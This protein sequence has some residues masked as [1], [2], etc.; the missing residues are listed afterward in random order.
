M[1]GSNKN[2][3]LRNLSQETKHA[4]SNGEVRKR[5]AAPFLIILQCIR[6]SMSFSSFDF[7]FILQRGTPAGSAGVQIP[8]L[9]ILR[10]R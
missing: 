9:R 7:L 1:T 2:R 10:R 4:R 5:R 6:C 8:S 3:T